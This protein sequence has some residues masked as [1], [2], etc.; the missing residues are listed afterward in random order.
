MEPLEW[1]VLQ[2]RG[3]RRENRGVSERDINSYQGTKSLPGVLMKL[4]MM[5]CKG[6][7]VNLSHELFCETLNVSEWV[8]Q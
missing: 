4:V 3:V 7:R 2:G 5:K 8:S 1:K 6:R